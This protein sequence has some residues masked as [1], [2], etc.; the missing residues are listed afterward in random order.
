MPRRACDVAVCDEIAVRQKDARVLYLRFDPCRIYR[1]DIG[2]IEEV[3]DPAESFGLTLR[4]ISRSRAIQAHQLGVVGGI[5]H[6]FDFE[7]ERPLRRLRD[8]EPMRR[9]DEAVLRQGLAVEA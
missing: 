8:G 1:H 2:T 6:G 5:E 9:G 3:S 4:A 7:I